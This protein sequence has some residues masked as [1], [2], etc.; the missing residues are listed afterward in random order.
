VPYEITAGLDDEVERRSDAATL[1]NPGLL[2]NDFVKTATNAVS[3]S[4]MSLIFQ[5]VNVSARSLVQCCKHTDILS[6]NSS[7]NCFPGVL[8]ASISSGASAR[9]AHTSGANMLKSLR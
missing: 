6:E 2:G 3:L 5:S 8:S 9:F 1:M 7:S 4:Y